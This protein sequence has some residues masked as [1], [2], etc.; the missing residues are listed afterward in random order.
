MPSSSPVLLVRIGS[1]FQAPFN[2][3]SGIGVPQTDGPTMTIEVFIPQDAG[4]ASLHECGLDGAASGSVGLD[5]GRPPIG[6]VVA[7]KDA[8]SPHGTDAGAALVIVGL[9]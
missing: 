3:L 8:A 2:H 9:V 6:W 5:H 1:A 4:H 7:L